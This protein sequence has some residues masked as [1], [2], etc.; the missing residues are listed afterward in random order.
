M[1]KLLVLILSL[2]MALG[3]AACGGDGG[4]KSGGVD[5]SKYPADIDEWTAQNFN[6]YFTEAGV[7]TNE[8][9]VYLDG[10]DIYAGTGVYE[11]G[12]YMD[13][14]GMIDLCVFIVDP[15][16]K[17]VDMEAFLTTIKETKAF[18]E[19]LNAIPLD[20]MVGNALFLYSYTA[21]EEVYDAFEKAYNDLITALGATPEF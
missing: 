15:D 19:E 17:E 21:D 12:G 6:D 4:D 1:K 13:D 10:H 3:L 14:A 20:H 11:C 16:S 18:P 7:Y 8:D 2:I 9:W 5:M